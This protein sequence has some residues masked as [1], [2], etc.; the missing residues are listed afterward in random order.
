M[1][2][3]WLKDLC[4][5]PDRV[6]AASLPEVRWAVLHVQDVKLSVAVIDCS[7]RRWAPQVTEGRVWCQSLLL[8]VTKAVRLPPL[9][10]WWPRTS[11]AVIRATTC[12]TRRKSST[13]SSR[14]W[15]AP[16][17]R[18]LSRTSPRPWWA[19]VPYGWMDLFKNSATWLTESGFPAIFTHSYC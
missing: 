10:R 1:V 17:C 5:Y 15:R 19:D 11:S 6:T 16:R 7:G 18:S 13:R 3:N 2:V 14:S 8:W 9:G 12:T 4:I